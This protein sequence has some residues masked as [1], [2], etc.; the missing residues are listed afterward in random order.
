MVSV[1]NIIR[2]SKK[3]QGRKPQLA[4]LR[5]DLEPKHNAIILKAF[6]LK[7]ETYNLIPH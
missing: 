6:N 2:K 1:W 4:V 5:A 7:V 3:S